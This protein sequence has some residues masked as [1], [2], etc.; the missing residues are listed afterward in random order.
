MEKQYVYDG[1]TW[2]KTEIA[3]LLEKAEKNPLPSRAATTLHMV[4]GDTILDVG[5]GIGIFAS[6]IAKKAKKV[7]AVDILESSIEIAQ[8]FYGA[9]NIDFLAGDLFTLNLPGKSFDCI[10]FLETI[11]H[12]DSPGK[13]LKEF[14]RLLKPN[15]YLILST[16]NAHSYA[17]ILHHLLFFNY[18]FAK[19]IANCIDNEERNTGTQNDHIYN[20]DFTTLYRLLNR[21]GFTY[22]DHAFTSYWPV[23]IPLKWLTLQFPFWTKGES[24]VMSIIIPFRQTLVFKVQK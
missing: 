11:E 18:R 2:S 1:K 14:H 23:I 3:A 9:D 5:C 19:K 15:G 22:T 20:W 8:D 17:N 13:F 6:R 16:P 4:E 10:L 24:W 12:V 7:V 21:N